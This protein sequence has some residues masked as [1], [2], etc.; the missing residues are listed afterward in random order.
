MIKVRSFIPDDQIQEILD[1]ISLEQ[2]ISRYVSLKPQGK[3]L[4]GLCPFHSENT[5]SFSVNVTKGLFYCFGC[6]AGGDIFSFIMKAENY[7][8]VEAAEFLASQAGVLLPDNK[9]I[10]KVDKAKDNLF[11]INS[12][13]QKFYNFMLLES[14]SGKQALDYLNNRGITKDIIMKFGLGYALDNWDSLLKFATN[15]NIKPKDLMQVGLINSREGNT[16]FYDRF[17]GRVMFPIYNRNGLVTGFGGRAIDNEIKGPKYLNSPETELFQKSKMLY[18]INLAS[19]TMRKEDLAILVEGYMD[20]IAAHKNGIKNTIATLGTAFTSEQADIIKRYTTNVVI[21]Y[22]ADKAGQ[23]AAMRAQ[24]ILTDNGSKVKILIL[25][26]QYDPD[27]YLQK[28]GP[29]KFMNSVNNLALSPIEYKIKITSKNSNFETLEGKTEAL[30]FILDDLVK[31]NNF[32]EKEYY[33]RLV[34]QKLG[35]TEQAV[36]AEII[37][38]SRDKQNLIATRD[39]KAIIRNNTKEKGFISNKAQSKAEVF[40]LKYIFENPEQ[41]NW[42]LEQVGLHSLQYSKSKLLVGSLDKYIE[43]TGKQGIDIKNFIITL[44]EEL[45]G[46]LSEIMNID[47]KPY[48][49]NDCIY[50][51]K[52][53]W[54][55][56]QMQNL[57]KEISIAE[58]QGKQEIVDTLVLSLIELQRKWKNLRDDNPNGRGDN[59]ERR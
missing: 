39:K 53:N 22:D 6:G 37:R 43:K 14:P 58:E 57:K 30:N 25:P 33:T 18:G 41:I 59:S 47:E 46:Y 21:A 28:F 40:L 15:R 9:L 27:D 54:F 32:L 44:P 16:G 10:K 13:A 20:V 52:N 23:E 5:P 8:F 45:Q 11:N 55:K 48:S 2:I 1:R 12:L 26:E 19:D 31:I 34:A 3:N 51:I 29:E 38:Y 4:V 50:I 35:I 17:R 24:S 42:F 36:N 49:I 7:S 56:L